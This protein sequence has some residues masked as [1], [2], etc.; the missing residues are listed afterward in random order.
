MS[1]Y[2]LPE[3]DFAGLDPEAFRSLGAM[4]VKFEVK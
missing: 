1:Y 4:V 2:L 3:R